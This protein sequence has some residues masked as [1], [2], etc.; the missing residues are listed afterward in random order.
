MKYIAH[1][2]SNTTLLARK[3]LFMS[4]SKFLWPTMIAVPAGKLGRLYGRF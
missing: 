2:K 4:V 3:N 1:S